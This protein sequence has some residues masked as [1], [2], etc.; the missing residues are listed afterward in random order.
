MGPD[1]KRTTLRKVPVSP[2]L[3]NHSWL[4]CGGAGEGAGCGPLSSPEFQPPARSWGG[5]CECRRGVQGDPCPLGHASPDLSSGSTAA[6][7]KGPNTEAFFPA[8]PSA[9]FFHLLLW[10]P[11]DLNREKA[12][13]GRE[14]SHRGNERPT[15]AEK[16]RGRGMSSMGGGREER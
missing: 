10:L 8:V 14:E 6:G 7:R 15:E 4:Q 3:W 2:W 13:A 11:I 12:G 16:G 1:P 5:G 9:V